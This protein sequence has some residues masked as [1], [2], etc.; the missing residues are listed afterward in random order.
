VNISILRLFLSDA[1]RGERWNA[2]RGKRYLSNLLCTCTKVY[3]TPTENGRRF[4]TLL[5]CAGCLRIARKAAFALARR[6]RTLPDLPEQA[7]F[8]PVRRQSAQT[9]GVRKCLPFSL[10]IKPEVTSPLDEYFAKSYSLVRMFASLEVMP[11]ENALE[12]YPSGLPVIY[13]EESRRQMC[14]WY[15]L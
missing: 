2:R 5:V 10:C 7:A 13:D 12:Q 6:K 4:L 11:K 14:A 15:I 9:S 3:N 8:H 1:L